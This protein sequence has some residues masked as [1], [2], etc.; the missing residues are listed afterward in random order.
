MSI[1]TVGGAEVQQTILARALVKAGYEVSMI[2]LDFGQPDEIEIDGVLVFRTHSPEDG[3]RFVRFL[4][5]RLTSAWHAMRRADADVY[6]QRG[7]GAITGWVALFCRRRGR[8]FIYAAASD[9]DLDPDVPVL[10]LRRDR[11]L[12]KAGIERADAVVV[13]NTSQAELC[14]RVLRREPELI[15]SC[16]SPPDGA[17]VDAD[18][19]VIWVSTLRRWKRPDLLLDLAARLPHL[20]FRMIGGADEPAYY[21]EIAARAEVLPNVEFVGFVPHADIE[22][23][24]DGA[25]ILV[26]TSTEFEGFPNTFLQAWARG[27]P[28]LSFV[29]PA[30]I[31]NE[32]EPPLA[33]DDPAE[34]AAA[35]GTLMTDDKTWRV[36][37]DRVRSYFID[38]HSVDQAAA[39]YARLFENLSAAVTSC[40]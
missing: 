9:A 35:I 36:A 22:R 31:L 3:V 6:Y 10:S 12:F 11:W 18:G 29:R 37:G 20:R 14:R 25:R 30:P 38:N 1:Q 4:H 39:R 26:N 27:M 34:M 24:F 28:T 8:R 17:R 21:S 2:C 7:A 19:Y 5:P 15:R 23:H 32:G 13:Q 40:G 33:V 16:Y